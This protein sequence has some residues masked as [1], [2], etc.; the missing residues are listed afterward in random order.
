[1]AELRQNTW[2]LNQWYDQNVDGT[3]GYSASGELWASGYN[4]N[5]VLG[6]NFIDPG[7]GN[8]GSR[9]SPI[10]IPGTTWTSVKSGHQAFLVQA[11]KIDGTLWTWGENQYGNLGHNNTTKYSS[12]VQIPG[13]TWSQ[14][15]RKGGVLYYGYGMTAIKTDGTLWA[16]GRNNYGELCQNNRT[17]YSSPK[18]IPGSWSQV[19]QGAGLK[20]DGT[21]WAWGPN[22]GGKLGQNQGYPALN[23]ASSP[24]QIPGD[25][26]GFYVSGTSAGNSDDGMGGVKTDGTLWSWGYNSQGQLG[27]N[28]V[29]PKSSP[30]QIPGNT[31]SSTMSAPGGGY[32]AMLK[33]TDG[34][35]W[36]TG[37]GYFGAS[38]PA[39]SSPVQVFE[40]YDT[41]AVA[42][43]FAGGGGGWLVNKGG[44][45]L[46]WGPSGYGWAGNNK[47]NGPASDVYVNQDPADNWDY[48]PGTLSAKNVFANAYT[49]WLVKP[50]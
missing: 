46:L 23:Y 48:S 3:V 22:Y 36:R 28:T 41:D 17:D 5:G 14:G 1:M 25:W 49:M 4:V 29:V 16:W 33:K 27:D 26:A 9:S 15:S 37:I 31:W 47:T 50:L 39:R 42:M 21:L 7:P 2:S 44:N 45:A 43:G 38:S 40:S 18:Q 12:P 34:T 8:S 10:K 6:A 20:T 30:I 35:L 11:T 19:E 13:T 32:A 24:V